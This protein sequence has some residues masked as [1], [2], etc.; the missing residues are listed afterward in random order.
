M[1]RSVLLALPIALSMNAAFALTAKESIALYSEHVHSSYSE[2]L[3]R[4]ELLRDALTAFAETPSVM[5]QGVAK[6][7]WKY[8]RESYGQT[9]AFRFYNGPI[10][11]DGGPEGL[12]NSWPLDEAYIDYVQGAPQS[13]II[14]NVSAYP[15]ITKELLSSLNELDGEKNV[16]TGYHAIEFLL[17]GQDFFEDGAG[18]RSYLDYVSAP[19]AERRKVYLMTVADLLVEHLSGLESAWKPNEKNYRAEFESMKE[20]QALKKILSGAI[21]MA[22]D[23][24]SGERIYVAYDTQG[25]EDEHSC[26]SDMTHMD[27]QWNYWGI[28]AV[29]RESRIL[30][31]AEVK[32]SKA[33]LKVLKRM[34][35]LRAKLATIPAPFDQ[36]IK[37]EASREIIL[38]SVEE[39]EGLAKDLVEVSKLLNAKV[40]Y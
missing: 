16:S 18:Q 40:D 21:F 24:L 25:Q 32:E 22:G 2:T 29:V 19:N 37:N 7:A 23:E 5:T 3:K 14:G 17:W 15:E 39:L 9:E 11:Q 35:A 20:T 38:S 13:G 6:E 33:S 36:A 30:E 27:I 34:S 1:L 8:A 31:L 28:E 10:D 4:A 12:M 26:F